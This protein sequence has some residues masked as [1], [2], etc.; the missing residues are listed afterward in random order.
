[1]VGDSHT[2]LFIFMRKFPPAPQSN[3][4]S[5]STFNSELHD[6]QKR[7][8]ADLVADN[9]QIFTDHPE[10]TTL[11][12][13]HI[14]TGESPQLSSPPYCIPQARQ[15][16]VGERGSSLY[17]VG[18]TGNGEHEP[19]GITYHAGTKEEWVSCL[20]VDYCKSKL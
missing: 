12:E 14:D 3:L 13:I 17:A 6:D 19:M 5:L 2:E 4:H 15:Q 16:L 20:C 9:Q 18:R 8:L 7:E 11:A 1:M 10:L